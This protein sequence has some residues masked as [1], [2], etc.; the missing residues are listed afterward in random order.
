[1]VK[2]KTL[3]Y[4]LYSLQDRGRLYIEANVEVY[5]GQIVGLHSRSNDLVVNPTKAKQLTNVRASGTDEALIL[6]RLCFIPLSKHW[7]LS[8]LTS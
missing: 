3:A 1:M 8:T 6:R 2:G 5:E 7:N 4:A